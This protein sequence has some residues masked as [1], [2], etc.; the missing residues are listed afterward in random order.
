MLDTIR[1]SAALPQ[2]PVDGAIAGTTFL[3]FLWLLS[4]G[5]IRPIWIYLLQLYLTF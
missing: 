4:T 1:K 2:V 3:A 5:Q